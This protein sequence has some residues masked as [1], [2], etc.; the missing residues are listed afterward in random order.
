MGSFP[1]FWRERI[2]RQKNAPATTYR[3]NHYL[4]SIYVNTEH[5]NNG[6]VL[7]AGQILG[8]QQA[9]IS[10][11]LITPNEALCHFSSL[12][13]HM[14]S[15]RSET[16]LDH[17]TDYLQFIS[18]AQSF[19]FMLNTS[20]TMAATLPVDSVW[21]QNTMR[22]CRLSSRCPGVIS[23]HQLVVESLLT[24]LSLRYPRIVLSCQLV[25]TTLP[26][27]VLSLHHTLLNSSCQLVVASLLLV[28]SLCPAPPLILLSRGWLL[29]CLLTRHPLVISSSQ[30]ATSHCLVP[31]NGCCAIISCRPLVAPPSCPL[32]ML[33]GC[34]VACSCTALSSSRRR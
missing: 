26:L 33:A 3:I 15:R 7:I 21:T 32:I 1:Y 5:P 8:N 27:A 16:L 2:N 11:S 25:V 30:R 10:W 28:L 19:W 4:T 9:K 24:V 31:P 18:N 14:S 12:I 34:C 22:L 17:I 29:L 13:L 20:M 23:S 6:N